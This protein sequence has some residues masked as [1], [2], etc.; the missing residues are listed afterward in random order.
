MAFI[1]GANAVLDEIMNIINDNVGISKDNQ[2]IMA[3]INELKIRN[4]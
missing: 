1:M 2:H 4:K 3:K